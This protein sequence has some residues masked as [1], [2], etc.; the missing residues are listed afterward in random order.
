VTGCA[1]EGAGPREPEAGRELLS[2]LIRA[3]ATEQ[4]HGAE[5]L[6]RVM[7]PTGLEGPDREKCLSA[8]YD[9]GGLAELVAVFGLP[10]SMSGSSPS[11]GF[12]M[13]LVCDLL[14]FAIAMH[15]FR[16]K[17]F[18]IRG[19]FAGPLRRLAASE[20]RFVQMAPVRL[21]RTILGT[22]DDVYLRW[23][24][25]SGLFGPIFRA[26]HCNLCPLSLGGGALVSAVLALLE[27]ARSENLRTL[28]DHLCRRHEDVLLRYARRFP[29][30]R[31]MFMQHQRNLEEASAQGRTSR[32]QLSP[33]PQHDP[34]QQ[35]Q[36]SFLQQVPLDQQP[37]QQPHQQPQQDHFPQKPQDED[38]QPQ[39]QQG[40]TPQEE[41]PPPQD[42]ALPQPQP[43]AEPPPLQQLYMQVR[44]QQMQHRPQL[45]RQLQSRCVFQ[46]HFEEAEE[47][48]EEMP[49]KR[50][51][52]LLQEG[53]A[54]RQA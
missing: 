28:I 39:S 51:R 14:A 53:R 48:A 15:G 32:A 34:S 23:V 31:N 6:K 27:Y 36:E 3:L 21:L 33:G 17:G 19:D 9:E 44:R 12:A 41:Q 42:Q 4:D 46:E 38:R 16:A 35:P 1:G 40:H 50:L 43:E 11:L 30:I 24:I 54:Q 20:Q 13:Q 2:N 29:V 7:D 5:L 25:R 22:R 26:F 47:E 37:G 49:R 45:R 10:P 18:I 52:T 8:F